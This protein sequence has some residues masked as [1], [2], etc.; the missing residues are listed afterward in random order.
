MTDA[1]GILPLLH[2]SVFN[3]TPFNTFMTL[4]LTAAGKGDVVEYMK[5]L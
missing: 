2:A 5:S 1:V 3:F 4:G